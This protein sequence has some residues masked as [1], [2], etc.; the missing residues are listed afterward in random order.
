MNGT[1]RILIFG[2]ALVGFLGGSYLV[3]AV[4]PGDPDGQDPL[5]VRQL[6]DAVA[7]DA[8]P[9]VEANTRF[10][11][12]LY[13]RLRSTPGN[14][15]FSP[16]SIST[17][18]AMTYAG[19]GGQTAEEMGTVLHTKGIANLHPVYGALVA[20]LDRGTD[21]GGYELRVAN[22]LW[23]QKG[24]PI[25]EPFLE[26]VREHYGAGFDEVDFAGNSAAARAAINRWVAERTR[27]RIQDL[28]PSGTITDLTRLVL[29]NAIYFKG[30]WATRFEP[31]RTADGPFH[32]AADRAVHVPM[33][34]AEM[35]LRMTRDHEISV[36]E[37]PYRGGDLAMILLLPAA[38]DGL[39]ALEASLTPERLTGWLDAAREGKIDVIIPRFKMTTEFELKRTLSD[40]GMP[41]AFDCDR[42]DLS[43]MTT[44][45]GWC[46]GTVRHKA[47]V[48][49]NEEGTEAA[50]ATGVGIALTSL[51]PSFVADHP[52]LFLI[53][54]RVTG[55][56]LFMGR[57]ADPSV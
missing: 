16:F 52:F 48:E 29:A 46:L 33:M 38:V 42:A 20:S 27:D 45:K 8:P 47:F 12:D 5:T 17:A 23:G 19:A 13:G 40:L 9:V 4:N 44:E 39:P 55:S 24:A 30:Q 14:L 32:V 1:G 28:F 18:L 2:A 34:H 36:L 3:C 56:I 54:D 35:T 50:A 7:A 49:V 11:L 10:A 21:L 25:R 57:V 22:S 26:T 31:D 51:P 37:M 41:S 53:R 6:P 43:A 15:F